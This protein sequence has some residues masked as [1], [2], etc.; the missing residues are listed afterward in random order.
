MNNGQLFSV[1]ETAVFFNKIPVM[2][3]HSHGFSDLL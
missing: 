3:H 1:Q 2:I